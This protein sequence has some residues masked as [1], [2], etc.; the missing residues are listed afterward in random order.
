MSSIGHFGGGQSLDCYYQELCPGHPRQKSGWATDR[1][2]LAAAGTTR[3]PGWLGCHLDLTA[4]TAICH[5]RQL[6][7]LFA[8]RIAKLADANWRLSLRQENDV[9]LSGVSSSSR[10]YTF[11]TSKIKS[12][13]G[14]GR[15]TIS[16]ITSTKH[17]TENGAIN[18][19]HLLYLAPVSGA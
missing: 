14:S 1:A 16:G 6:L 15:R 13:G 12:T 19:L 18:R 7:R 17:V 8:E 9:N 2:S 10:W 11:P 4:Q 3:R 5:R